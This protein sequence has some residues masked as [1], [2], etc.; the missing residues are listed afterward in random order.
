MTIIGFSCNEFVYFILYFQK[1]NDY[2][3]YIWRFVVNSIEY[4]IILYRVYLNNKYIAILTI[5]HY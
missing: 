2:I 3:I 5:K 1:L 4:I